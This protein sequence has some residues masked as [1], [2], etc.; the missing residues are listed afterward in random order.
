MYRRLGYRLRS[1]RR[2]GH[3]GEASF[4][5]LDIETRGHA[6]LSQ[7]VFGAAQCGARQRFCF[8]GHLL[9]LVKLAVA[10]ERDV[11]PRQ[12]GRFCSRPQRALERRHGKIIADQQ[13]A[14]ADLAAN[15]AMNDPRAGGCGTVGVDGLVD[16]MRVIAIGA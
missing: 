3:F 6:Q 15:D 4:G 10:V 11:A 7:R 13:T 9:H 5:L 16:D 1:C 8:A 12:H 14:K 2:S